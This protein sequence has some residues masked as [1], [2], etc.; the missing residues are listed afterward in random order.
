M[1]DTRPEPA[2]WTLQAIREVF[3]AA[4]DHPDWGAWRLDG[5]ALTHPV[6]A[7]PH[8]FRYSIGLDHIAT[9][10]DVLAWVLH[11]DGKSWGDPIG[12][13]RAFADLLGP[14]VVPRGPLP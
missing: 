9:S 13:L 11:I 3:A 2:V 12:L 7:H 6:C 10:D 1:T 5:N 8:A 14:E 4:P